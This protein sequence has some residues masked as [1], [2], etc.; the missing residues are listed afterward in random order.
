ML[1]VHTRLK[2]VKYVNEGK[3]GMNSEA[4]ESRIYLASACSRS[5]R[6]TEK[7]TLVG[8]REVEAVQTQL[9]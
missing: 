9:L 8:S 4:S 1:I 2:N 7:S 5:R 3:Q 6:N